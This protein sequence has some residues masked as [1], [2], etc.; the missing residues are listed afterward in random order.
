MNGAGIIA[1]AQDWALWA[2]GLAQGWLLSPAAW[3]QFGLL[4]ASWLL[5][6]LV[7]RR[8]RPQLTRLLTPPD[9]TDSLIAKARRFAL[10]FLPLLL[11]LL[12][13]AFTAAGE[14]ATRALFGS[15]AVIAF[16]KR[17]FLFLAARILVREVLDRQFPALPWPLCADPDRGAERAGPAGTGV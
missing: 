4:V 9:G 2:W 7:A 15:G 13:Y 11:P 10:I 8:L 5:A 14:Q 1:Q 12:A 6:V 3:T 17:V 16:G